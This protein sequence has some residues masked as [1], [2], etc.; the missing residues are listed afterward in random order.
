MS[1]VCSSVNTYMN[2]ASQAWRQGGKQD[3]HLALI[4]KRKDRSGHRSKTCS[5]VRKRGL[6][7]RDAKLSREQAGTPGDTAELLSLFPEATRRA[8]GPVCTGRA[9][10]AGGKAGR[11]RGPIRGHWFTYDEAE[12]VM[13]TRSGYRRHSLGE[14]QGGSEGAE[15]GE[16]GR[17]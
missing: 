12:G 5:V 14:Q 10:Y 4:R 8:G 2:K 6:Y 9:S 3:C 16:N 7:Q 15:L 1:I 13:E 17:V 11:S